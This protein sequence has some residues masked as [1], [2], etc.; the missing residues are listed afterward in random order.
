[1]LWLSSK[2]FFNSANNLTQD[3]SASDDKPFEAYGKA[4]FRA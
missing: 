2:Q 3:I 1:M 4:F